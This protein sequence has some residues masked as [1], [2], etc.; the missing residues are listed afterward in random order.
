MK[1]RSFCF[2]VASMT[3]SMGAFAFDCNNPPGGTDLASAQANYQCSEKDRITEDAKLN[4]VYKKLVGMLKD[5]PDKETMPKSQIVAAQRAWV[6]FRDAECDF[7]TSL[8]G[9]VHQWLM[10]NHSQ[11]LAE[12]TSQRTKVLQGYLEQAHDQ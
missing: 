1:L 8:N 12:V 7:R 9:G 3:F 2:T 11:C 5:D 10:V 6:A 4:Q